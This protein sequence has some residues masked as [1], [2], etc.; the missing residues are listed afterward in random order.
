M[1][2][3][4]GLA[5]LAVVLAGCTSGQ[6]SST[7][8]ESEL[9]TSGDRL[10]LTQLTVAPAV[11]RVWAGD[12]IDV[13]ARPS[14]DGR[15]FSLTDWKTGS[16]VLHDIASGTRR[17][18]VES[19]TAPGFKA[20]LGGAKDYAE[21]TIISPDGKTV[22]Y[23]WWVA[24]TDSW[25][26]RIAGLNG[27]DAG[28]SR[29]IYALPG[30]TFIGAQSWTPDGTEVLSLVSSAMRTHQI[31]AV[32]ANGR[33][34]RI[35]RELG[36]GSA[37]NITV[38][39]DGQWVAYDHKAGG[40][41]RDVY[42]A[43][44]DGKSARLVA[45]YKGDDVV[46]GW[47]GANGRLLIMSNRSGTPSAW[48]L[49]IVN[50][51]P[52][53]EPILVRSSM[54]NS[55]P[56]GTA[57]YNN[58]FYSV[59]VG[60]RDV[61]TLGLEPSSGAV[62]SAGQSITGGN[63]GSN[64]KSFAWSSDGQYVAYQ[65]WRG[66]GFGPEDIIVRSIA[67]GEIRRLSPKMAAI[68]KMLWYPDGRALLLDG[69][70]TAGRVGIFRMDI[71]NGSLTPIQIGPYPSPSFPN[72]VT[73]APDGKAIAFATDSSGILINILDPVS[74][75]TVEL[76]RLGTSA[77]QS[78]ALAFSPDGKSFAVAVKGKAP[79]T[80]RLMVV[81]TDG[82]SE[83]EV[84]RLPAT[85]DF[86]WDG[87]AWM[88]NSRVLVFGVSSSSGSTYI[89]SLRRLSLDTDKVASIGATSPNMLAFNISP[90][91]RTLMYGVRRDAREMWMMEQPVFDTNSQVVVSRK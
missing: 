22:A 75:K 12:G 46:M 28:M 35:V 7:A 58:S 15:S 82:R 19:P 17:R 42:V 33:G 55:A 80:S 40:A 34:I 89:T 88:P 77:D 20:S 79:G 24:K 5:A 61:Y 84:H 67:R 59:S 43:S 85:E 3:A 8:T 65:V 16:V 83:R 32:N 31:V 76:R 68:L 41:D 73:F 72:H 38:S 27:V 86:A 9:S 13:E 87:L 90:D 26:L 25:E 57:A 44:I 52:T 69:K 29:T 62:R 51:K 23:G 4:I 6:R 48:A 30:A 53:G 36:K 1:T 81:S 45:R 47:S 2:R 71:A 74:G 56:N 37:H 64:P 49:T 18:L 39:P 21:E 63:Q 78:R 91:G 50:G 10:G 54:W 66:A 14:P 70:D 11:R 60:E